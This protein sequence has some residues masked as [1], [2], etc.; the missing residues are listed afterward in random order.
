MEKLRRLFNVFDRKPYYYELR[1]NF[2]K[3]LR[4]LDRESKLTKAVVA[5]LLLSWTSMYQVWPE[6][7]LEDYRDIVLEA[8]VPRKEKK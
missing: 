1:D 3:Q 4:L 8:L 7:T 5:S 2:F 6:Q